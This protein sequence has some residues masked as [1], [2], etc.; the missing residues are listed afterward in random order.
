MPKKLYIID[1]HAHIYSAYYAPMRPLTGP[2]GEPTKA[3]YI[4]TTAMLGLIDRAKPD[5]LVVAMDS[6]APS[7]RV[8]MYPEYKA[9][10]APMPEDLPGQIKQIERILEAMNIPMLRV[11]GWEADDIIG[12]LTKEAD[13]IGTLTKEAT[14]KGIDAFICSKDKDMLQLLNEHV[15]AYDIKK[16]LVTDTQSLKEDKGLTPEQFIDVL[17]LQG[18]AADNIPGVPDVGPKT[19]TDWIKKYGSL[20]E[21]Y[22]HADEIKGKRGDNL[23]NFKDQAYLSKDLVIINTKAPVEF[24]EEIFAYCGPDTDKLANIYKELGFTKLLTSLGVQVEETK[25]KKK[26]ASIP[27]GLFAGTEGEKTDHKNKANYELIDTQEKLDSFVKELSKQDT[28]AFD[29]ETTSIN[30]MRADLVG[31]SFSWQA[32]TGYY[33][34][35]KAP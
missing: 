35:V 29:T 13:I 18:D 3:V 5:M 26:S 24:D 6:K 21:L 27:G 22:A 1:G 17:A 9:H 11:D 7:F 15:V 30:A 2:S 10:R 16:D 4:F 34:P 23:R 32:N 25:P 31:M 19:A 12:T 8:D 14:E 20:D 33:L 28:F